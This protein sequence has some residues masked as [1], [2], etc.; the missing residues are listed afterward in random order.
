MKWEATQSVVAPDLM[1]LLSS[2]ISASDESHKATMEFQRAG[3]MPSANGLAII[4]M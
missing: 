4:K 3:W 2:L 1:M